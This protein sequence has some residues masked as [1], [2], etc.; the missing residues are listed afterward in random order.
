MHKNISILGGSGFIGSNLS[1][2]L[3]GSQMSFAIFDLHKSI[4]FPDVSEI[5][6]VRN[7][8]DVRNKLDGTVVVNL[9]AVHRDD[10]SD[11]DEYYSTN[12]EGARVLCEVCDEK[13]IN[14][15]V[16]TSSVAVYGFAP[17][18]TGEEGSIDPF[19]EYGR[20][21]ALAEDVYRRWRDKD[22]KNRSLIIVRP[23]VVFG[24]GNRGNVYNLFNQINS[25]AFAMIVM[26]K[27]QS[28]WL[29]SKTSAPF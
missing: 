5:V 19:N 26:E 20:T 8:S 23:T 18:G 3:S 14:K 1:A 17:P 25:G 27:T 2:S 10:I 29:M 6:D 22:P 11:P 13:G 15:I 24:E 12:V 28:L 16:F 4:S 21:K 7:I 9:A